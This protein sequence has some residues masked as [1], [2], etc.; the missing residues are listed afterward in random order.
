MAVL[1]AGMVLGV[2]TSARALQSQP[3]GGDE[4]LARIDA[5]IETAQAGLDAPSSEALRSI[6][7]VGAPVTLRLSG[8]TI[9]LPHDPVL[10]ELG[11]PSRNTFEVALQRLQRLREALVAAATTDEVDGAELDR[12]VAAAYRDLDAS[13]SI[14]ERL[15]RIAQDLLTRIAEF[16]SG[17]DAGVG[18]AAA[19]ILGLLGA[20]GVWA[21]TRRLLVVADE[22]VTRERPQPQRT[23]DD[24]QAIADDALAR[25]DLDTA[26]RAEY[27]LLVLQLARRGIVRDVPSL[28]PAEARAAIRDRGQLAE[29]VDVATEV[30]ERMAYGARPPRHDEVERMRRAVGEVAP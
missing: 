4:Y 27:Q 26:V 21:L 23:P 18:L 6:E 19:I 17:A 11:D 1:I 13:M 28:T 20:A 3:I 24:W 14:P 15:W 16:I 29:P 12:A 8:S 9:D 30:F 2:V 5:A 10:S 25:G 7:Q 22:H